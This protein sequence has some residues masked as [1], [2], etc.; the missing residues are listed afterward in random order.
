MLT[1]YGEQAVIAARLLGPTEF[2]EVIP[3]A[4]TSSTA[5]IDA[6]EALEW[7]EAE[8]ANLSAVVG[9][10]AACGLPG[11]ATQTPVAMREFFKRTSYNEI[12][13]A[14]G[15]VGVRSARRLGDDAA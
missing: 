11:I 12:R 7:Y 3:A 4:P 9:Q 14:M 6:A 13:V 5:M 15:E 2:P 8:L 10:A 1:W